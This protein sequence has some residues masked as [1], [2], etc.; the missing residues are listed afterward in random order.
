MQLNVI[1]PGP[2]RLTGWRKIS[3]SEWVAGQGVEGHQGADGWFDEICEATNLDLQKLITIAK[4]GGNW[5][6][7][8][9]HQVVNKDR[10]RYDETR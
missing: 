2:Y 9:G 1:P 4:N 8:A 7:G 6:E 5:R 3:C 10:Y